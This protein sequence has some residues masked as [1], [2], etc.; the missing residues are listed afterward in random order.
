VGDYTIK[1][2]PYGLYFFKHTLKKATFVTFPQTADKDKAT[3]ADLDTLYK[4]GL[5][6]AV[7]KRRF[8][9]K[10]KT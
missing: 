7:N 9:P 2:G 1:T 6:K 5:A 4:D 8:K 10:D 3:S